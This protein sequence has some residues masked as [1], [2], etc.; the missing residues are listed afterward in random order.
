MAS[1]IISIAF[2]ID[3]LTGI[4]LVLEM[5]SVVAY[6][7]LILANVVRF[8]GFR[9]AFLADVTNPARSFG[10]FTFVAGSGVLGSRMIL[11]GQIDVGVSLGAVAAVAWVVLA[12][13][14]GYSLLVHNDEPPTHLVNGTWLVLT[15]GAQSVAVVAALLSSRVPAWNPWLWL[16]ATC[17]WGVGVV[18][19]FAVILAV[20]GRLFFTPTRARDVTPPYWINMGA[21]AITTL[22][23]ARLVLA[24]G[25][26]VPLASLDGF[27]L[28]LTVVLWAFGTWWIPLLVVVGWWRYR[29]GGV[30]VHY[31]PGL[32]SMVFP[33]GMYTVSTVVLST[34]PGLHVLAA[35][36]PYGLGVAAAA[37]AA[38]MAGYVVHSLAWWRR[39]RRETSPSRALSGRE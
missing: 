31:E 16:S 20:M 18:F 32:W 21:L 15:V 24:S 3:K 29:R 6:L 33:L 1:S 13:G 39:L 17:F 37:W 8:A 38:T 36:F 10:Y 7:I 9:A 26:A 27:V 2:L 14:H 28:G 25:H 22:A 12:Y 34:I 5:I 19:Y 4:S 30:P 35:I 23:G 11:G